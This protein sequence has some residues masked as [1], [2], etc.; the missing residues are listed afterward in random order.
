MKQRKL[1]RTDLH[2]SEYC[3]DAAALG[4]GP[5]ADDAASIL[6]A[7]RRAGGNFIQLQADTGDAAGDPALSGLSETLVGRWL[8]ER[9]LA[10]PE[11]VLSYCIHLSPAPTGWSYF[12]LAVEIRA[13]CE[14]ALRRLGTSYL[15]LLLVRWSEEV[16]A[17]DFLVAVESL[18]RSGMFRHLG[19]ADFPAWRAMEWIGHADRRRLTRLDA[20]QGE[21]APTLDSGSWREMRDLAR[22]QRL[23]LIVRPPFL[24]PSAEERE[25]APLRP[26]STRAAASCALTQLARK[27]GVPPRHIALAWALA[28]PA[29]SAVLVPAETSA[30]VED[31]SAAADLELSLHELLEIG[32]PAPAVA[33]PGLHA[34]DRP[35]TVSMTTS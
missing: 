32:R 34:P 6:D 2:I 21:V 24:G 28:D 13:R 8:Q 9:R 17:D 14:A 35:E 10:R 7:F 5:T 23:G 33:L 15:D 18:Q 22:H 27:R 30:Q 31:L 3:L 19:G 29:V 4:W 11:V 25:R 16:P 12:R 26:Y 20:I 1:G